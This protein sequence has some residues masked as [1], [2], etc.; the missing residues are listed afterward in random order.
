MA[1]HLVGNSAYGEKPVGAYEFD[2]VEAVFANQ[3]QILGDS[4]KAAGIELLTNLAAS[5]GINTTAFAAGPP[6]LLAPPPADCCYVLPPPIC[7]ASFLF[8]SVF[9]LK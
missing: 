3:S 5:V 7:V 2:F 9:L 1:D 8:E 6:P 4:T